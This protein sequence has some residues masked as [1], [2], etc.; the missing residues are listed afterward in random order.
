MKDKTR[1]YVRGL[2]MWPNLI[3][4]DILKTE[5]IPITNLKPQMI[6]LFPEAKNT[7][8]VHRVLAIK[9]DKDK[10][11]VNT[12][13]DR[14]GPDQDN[15]NYQAN[16]TLLKIIG[17]LRKGQYRTITKAKIPH[18]ISPNIIIRIYNKIIRTLFW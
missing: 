3:P 9:H 5:E 8:I 18:L 17:V 16:D 7:F 2:S 11:I 4:G 10:I 1:G 6:A 13:G 12:G 14:S 15:W